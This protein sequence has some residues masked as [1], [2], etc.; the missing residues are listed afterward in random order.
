MNY[1]QAV[2]FL[3][4]LE[5][6]GIKLGLENTYSLMK[7]L[8]NPHLKFSSI[9]VAGTNG[10]G[11]CCAMLYSILRKAGYSCGIYTSPHLVDFRERIRIDKSLIEKDYLTDFVSDLK[12][13]ILKKKYTFFEVITALAFSYFADRKIELGVVETGL[14]GRLDSTNILKPQVAIIT[15]IG[16]EH[17]DRLGRTLEKIAREKGGII[18]DNVPTVTSI[19]REKPFKVIESLCRQKKSELFS[20]FKDSKWEI[21]ESSIEG[22]KFNLRTGTDI[23]SGIRLNLAGEHQIRN[24]A[25][26]ILAV[27]NLAHQGLKVDKKAIFSGLSKVNWPGRLEVYSRNPLV[28][29]DVAHN[30]DGIINLV[31]ALKN[32]LPDK[33]IYFVFGV[34]EDKNYR[35]MLRI[36]SG[37]AKEIILTQP[38]YSRSARLDSLVDSARKLGLRYSAVPGVR[39]ACQSAL[40][41]L[42]KD[43]VLCITGSHFTLGE[44][45]SYRKNEK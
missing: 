5:K 40:K 23:Y 2:D 15:N 18:K 8:G 12:G 26:A 33:N 43:E 11:S 42:K 13:E 19:E 39:E 41:K 45:L 27:E 14:G 29:L 44:F 30:P 31:S 21:K 20:I 9:H 37:I 38:D 16:L 28:I 17:T 3:F 24:A 36:M 22:I 10:K 7:R 6:F 25:C 34:M 32:L 4:S 1:Q 35:K